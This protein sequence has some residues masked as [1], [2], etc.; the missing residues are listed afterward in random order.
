M[1]SALAV[2]AVVVPIRTH[3]GWS[4]ELTLDEATPAPSRSVWVTAQLSDE[5]ARTAED[6]AWLHVLAW[7]GGNG[8]WSSDVLGQEIV[9]MRETSAGV[10]RSTRPVPVSGTWKSFLRLATPTTLQSVPIY[11]PADTAIPATEVPAPAQ[12]TRAFVT[13]HE[14][15]QREAVGGSEAVKA[16]AYIGL[17][18]VGLMWV[19]CIAAGARRL[20]RVLPVVEPSRPRLKEHTS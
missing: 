4:A 2:L 8:T 18:V 14:L 19:L 11:L 16:A 15:L 7:Q 12:V 1:A 9:P 5:A 6:P 13:D 10:W 17:G 3:H 20:E